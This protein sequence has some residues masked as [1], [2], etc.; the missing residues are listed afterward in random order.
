M[1]TLGSLAFAVPWALAALVVLP[2]IWLL[3]RVTP[4]A[5]RRLAFPAIAFLLGL[6]PREETPARTPWWLILLRLTAAA[7]VILGLAR[8]LLDP[9]PPLAGT[10]PLILALDD[11]WASASQWED[12]RRA[13]LAAIDEAARTDRPVALLTTAPDAGGEAPSLFGPR[14]AEDVI[15]RLGGLSPK[16]WPVDRAAAAKALDALRSEGVAP[17]VYIADGLADAALDPLYDAL[18]RHGPLRLV[19][20]QPEMLPALALPPENR[21]GDLTVPVRR[22]ATEAPALLYVRA[23]AADGRTLAREPLSFT[24]GQARAEAVLKLPVEL[25]NAV[26]RIDLE[27][28][29]QTGAAVLID[30][31]YQ[32][33]PVGIVAGGALDQAQSL[34]QDQ[35]YLERALAPFAELRR[36]GL[37]DLLR[38]PPALLLLGDGEATTDEERAALTRFIEGGGVLTRFAGDTLAEQPDDPLLPVRLRQGGRSLGTAMQ[39]TEPARLSPFPEKSPFAGLAIPADV[40]V[41]RQVLAEPAPDLADHTWAR[42]AD[43]TPLVTAEQRGQGWLVL[44]HVPA[45]AEWSNLPISGLFVDMLRRLVGLGRGAAAAGGAALPASET[46]DG[47]AHLQ[48]APSFAAPLPGTQSRVDASHPPGFYGTES[49]RRALNLTAATVTDVTQAAPP[50]SGIERAGLER[51]SA[52][53][54]GPWLIVAALVLLLLDMLVALRLRGLLTLAKVAG[55]VLL[56]MLGAHQARAQNNDAFALEATLDTRLAYVVTG[57]SQ[58]D[59]VSKAGLRGLTLVLNRRTAVE[60]LEPVAVDVEADELA[61][62]PLLYWPISGSQQPVSRLAAEKLNAF[63]HNGGTILFDTRDSDQAAFDPNGR[64]GGARQLQQLVRGL[65][66]PPLRQVPAE[67]VLTKTFYLMQDFPGRTVGGPLWIQA[68]VGSDEVASVL[69]GSNDYAGAWATDANGRPLFAASPGNEL[70]REMAYRFGVNLVMY[71]LTG[72]YKSDQVHV[73]SILERLGQ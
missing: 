66:I 34:L 55:V 67:H 1:L 27:G 65:D 4:P 57:D 19:T 41:H 15:Q 28:Q 21:P 45:A 52:K 63:L 32:R 53:D 23:L 16:P 58:V 11:G 29:N 70:Q 9:T 54:L 26:V 46:L 36:G 10:G 38:A 7:L 39:W 18:R 20:G 49:G 30:D 31:R 3:L 43:G 33:R 25:R 40:L 8:P 2:V 68:D 56:G 60:A 48:A 5:P 69:V 47:F 14:R 37:A 73:P 50:P 61:F 59:E 6:N 62:F 17:S 13:A 72:N 51:G 44:F 12:R 71:A 42:L 35:Y 24:A 64:G 22:A